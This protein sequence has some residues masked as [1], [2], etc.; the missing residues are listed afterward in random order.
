M[1]K[2]KKEKHQIRKNNTNK[3]LTNREEEEKYRNTTRPAKEEA[4]ELN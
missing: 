3:T 1:H 4:T 2:T